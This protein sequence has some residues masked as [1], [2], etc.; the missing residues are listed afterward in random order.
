MFFKRVCKNKHL[1]YLCSCLFKIMAHS[2]DISSVHGTG[3][4]FTTS[5]N[6]FDITTDTLADLGGTNTGP[7]PKALMLVSLTGCTGI[8]V[9]GILTKMKVKYSDLRIDVHADL[10][11]EIAAINVSKV[12][13]A[14]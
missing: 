1:G 11:D 5:L 6:G 8:D 13:D 7:R 2:H 12:E 9:V 14:L 10:T 4:A 3:M